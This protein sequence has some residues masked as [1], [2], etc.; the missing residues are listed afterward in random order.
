MS[1]KEGEEEEEEEEKTKEEEEKT[2]E[3][4]D[5]E[6]QE[7]SKAKSATYAMLLGTNPDIISTIR[8]EDTA[9]E[10]EGRSTYTTGAAVLLFPAQ[11]KLQSH[12]DHLHNTTSTTTSPT[13][14]QTRAK[15]SLWLW[16][17]IPTT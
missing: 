9:N 16:G 14:A 6:T 11:N 13:W 17:L 4:E 3:E 10:S 8:G 7:C 15:N 2:K 5:K 12:H 1:R